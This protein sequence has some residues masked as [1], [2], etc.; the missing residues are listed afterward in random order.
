MRDQIKAFALGMLMTTGVWACCDGYWWA[1]ITTM[2][3]LVA[4]LIKEFVKEKKV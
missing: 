1:V 2:V 4:F 3:V